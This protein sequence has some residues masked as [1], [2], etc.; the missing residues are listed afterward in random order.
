MNINV[1]A[2]HAQKSRPYNEKKQSNCDANNQKPLSWNA[3]RCRVEMIMLSTGCW[4]FARPSQPAQ[5]LDSVLLPHTQHI[6]K[7]INTVKR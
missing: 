1:Q 3:G 5:K 7:P 6:L 2:L 4:L